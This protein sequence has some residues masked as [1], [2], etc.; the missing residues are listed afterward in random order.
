M[1][2]QVVQHLV[3]V[4]VALDLDV[5]PH[6][7]AVRLVA[8]V[9]DP[10]DPL[11]LD[12]VRDLLEERRL[13]DLVWQLRDDD[14]HPVAADLLEGDLGAHDDAAPAVGVHLA[15]RVDRLPLAGRKIG[16]LDVLAQA[17]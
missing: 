12:E 8:Q 10:V 15:D 1:L 7:V 4:R 16:A 11:V 9:A 5:D 14:R 13:V 6:P 3:G 2:E 17:V